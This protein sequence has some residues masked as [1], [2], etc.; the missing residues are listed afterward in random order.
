MKV[1][2]A[3]ADVRGLCGQCLGSVFLV[4]I[5]TVARQEAIEIGYRGQWMGGF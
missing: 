2:E 3:R 5:G 4:L 1:Q